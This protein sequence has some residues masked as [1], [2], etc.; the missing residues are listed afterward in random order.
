MLSNILHSLGLMKVENFQI[1]LNKE[2]YMMEITPLRPA[3]GVKN[4]N[5]LV[6]ITI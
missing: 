6:P 4:L 2:P 5:Y 3:A 1:H